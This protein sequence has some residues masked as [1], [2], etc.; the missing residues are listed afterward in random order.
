MAIK[1]FSNLLQ[2]GARAGYMP[3]KTI[4]SRKW[5]RDQAK[6]MSASATTVHSSGSVR[7]TKP[8]MGAMY[9]FQYGAKFK[10]RL[11]FWDRWPLC[12]PVKTASI[13]QVGTGFYGLN[14]H[15]LP[16]DIRAKFMD[17]LY[18][19]ITN[20]KYDQTTRFEATYTLL[21]SISSFRFF[22]PCFKHY[23]MS[24]VQ[25]NF[26]YIDPKQWDMALF[27]PLADWQKASE[28]TVYTWSKEQY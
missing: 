6:S 20:K 12:I 18:N 9:L 19:L 13:S 7:T 10:Q 5:F 26:L 28:S 25:G 15:Y 17:A 11:P 3:N 22:R 1:V 4:E 27:M 16:L 21:K 24:H 23:L 8:A 2:A 14:L